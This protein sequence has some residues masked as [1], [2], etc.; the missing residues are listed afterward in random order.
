MGIL[1]S[2]FKQPIENIAFPAPRCSYTYK[3]ENLHFVKDRDNK[4]IAYIHYYR[5]KKITIIYSHG[6]GTDIGYMNYLCSTLARDLNA[7]VI[8]Y[9]YE[10]YGLS[11]GTPSE[12]G[13]I[14]GIESVYNYV[15]SKGV[16][17]SDIIL[18]GT[19]IG[20]G[21]TVHLAHKLAQQGI[22]LKGIL[23]Q[24]P[25]K[26][27]V[28]VI[29]QSLATTSYIS[30]AG[31]DEYNPDLFRTIDKIGSIKSPITIIHGLLD[32]V[33]PYDH[34]VTLTKQNKYI[35]LVTL[36]DASHNNIDSD[37]YDYV[38]NCLYEFMS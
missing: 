13:C 20:T 28:S 35:K 14:N 2:S 30:S 11:E 26:S 12:R 34:S 31:Y 32:E 18:Y 22:N 8:L 3:T 29:S 16:N 36:N 6:N 33:I 25:Y 38:K 24:T 17:P 9:D 37:Y 7:N 1:M 15:V 19:S 4:Q 21:P 5:N 27:V 10:G 23:L